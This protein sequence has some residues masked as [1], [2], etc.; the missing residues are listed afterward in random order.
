MYNTPLKWYTL[1]EIGWSKRHRVGST[2]M[3]VIDYENENKMH[4]YK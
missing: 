3:M 4:K 2:I 1:L